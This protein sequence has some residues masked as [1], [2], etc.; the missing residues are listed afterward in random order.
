MPPLFHLIF[1]LSTA[2]TIHALVVCLYA[3][4]QPPFHVPLAWS[5]ETLVYLFMSGSL[6]AYRLFYP[7]SN[8]KIRSKAYFFYLSVL[9]T[10]GAAFASLAWLR[11]TAS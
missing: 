5:N 8:E 4:Q 11:F 7:P 10:W 1:V 3:F 6:C 9:T 2:Q